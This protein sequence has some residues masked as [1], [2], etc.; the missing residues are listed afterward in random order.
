MIPIKV[1]YCRWRISQPGY[2]KSRLI[3]MGECY[4]AWSAESILIECKDL[5][6]DSQAGQDY[7]HYE[8][9]R[10]KYIRRM[11]WYVKKIRQTEPGFWDTSL[12][13]ES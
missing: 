8:R 11:Y 6:K 13:Y 3:E 1:H 12:D 2:Y 4:G 10:D 9:M 5:E 7:Q